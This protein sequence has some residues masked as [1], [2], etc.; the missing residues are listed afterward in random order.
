MFSIQK[1]ST[2]ADGRLPVVQTFLEDMEKEW[3]LLPRLKLIIVERV[4]MR[5]LES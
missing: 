1:V 4:E 2:K 5:S 3:K